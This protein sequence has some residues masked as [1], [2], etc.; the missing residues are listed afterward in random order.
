MKDGQG[1]RRLSLKNIFYHNTFV[2]AFSFA[3]ALGTWFVMAANSE[4]NDT[5]TIYDVPIE[6]SLS[7]EAEA[8]GL[9]V[10]N[11]SYNTVDLEISGSS[12]ITSKLTADDFRVSIP[13]NPTS[14][15]L[16]GNTLQKLTV[17]VRAV[18]NTLLSDY[19]IVSV[20]PQEI[21][22]E[23]DRYKEVTLPLE[24][25][26]QFS[27]DAGYYPG[28]PV[29]SEDSVTISGPESSVN[30]ISRAAVSYSIDTPLRETDEFSSPV[31]L[32]DQD[33]KE[34]TDTSSMFLS[35]S[36]DTV[37]VSIPVLSRK[38]VPLVVNTVR[39]PSGFSDSRITIEPAQIDLAGSQ[40]ALADISEIR[41]AGVVDFGDLS[42]ARANSL[43]M[44]IP[45]PTGVRNITNAGENTVNQAT[46]TVNLNGYTQATVTVP[47]SN[48]Q[49]VNE[50][51]GQ[52]A[53]LTTRS[54]ELTVVGPQAQVSKLTGDS[55]SLQI[56]LSNF[57]GRS[58]NM[59]VPLTAAISGTAGQACWIA[60]SYTATLTLRDGDSLPAGASASGQG[61]EAL[62]AAPQE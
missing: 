38:T 50:P 49:I 41:L 23:Y 28:S 35:L 24:D 22:V 47:E 40:E 5:Y 11:M 56:D 6:V 9:R 27:A 3:I 57:A 32:Y 45:L 62:V 58:G 39:Q 30:K 16:T 44:E 25:E 17:P 14:T 59:E 52:K 54:V 42:A 20:S 26:I 10:F 2:L 21:N 53:E 31:R 12:L 36:V 8:D 43:V 15:K 13:L 4:R 60:G 7:A 51:A 34:I 19:E 48:I 18:K 33:N 55:V 46:V 29:L 61:S 37:Q 1:K